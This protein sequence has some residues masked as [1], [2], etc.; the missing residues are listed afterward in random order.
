MPMS[1]GWKVRLIEDE[2]WQKT[3]GGYTAVKFR[4]L[5]FLWMEPTFIYTD[6][7]SNVM[8]AERTFRQVARRSILTGQK[9]SPSIYLTK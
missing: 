9:G 1:H 3:G 7:Q 8:T 2:Q 5:L 4:F 6:P